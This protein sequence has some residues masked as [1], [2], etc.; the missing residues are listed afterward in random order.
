[1]EEIRTQAKHIEIEED[2]V[3]RLKV[4]HQHLVP[5]AKP[6]HSLPPRP[7]PREGGH[8]I[9]ARPNDEPTQFTPLKAREQVEIRGTV[10]IE[11]VFEI[12]TNA[13]AIL[14]TYIVVN[15]WASYNMII[16]RLRVVVPTPHLY[17]KYPVGM[18]VGVIKIARQC[19]ED[20]LRVGHKPT[21]Y[22]EANNGRASINF[23]DLDPRQ[24]PLPAQ[25]LKEVQIGPSR[26]QKTRIGV[27]LGGELEECLTRFLTKNQDVFN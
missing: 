15:T 23:L 20:N 1:M 19:Y 3:D 14:V 27:T 21:D 9:Q 10:E 25:D 17:M 2:L 24:Q 22:E 7:Y 11:T 13:R 4:E 5:Q 18:S 16:D 6:N 8:K 26:T 12:G